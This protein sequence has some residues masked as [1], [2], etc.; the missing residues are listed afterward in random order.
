MRILV[1]W[2]V[3]DLV[4]MLLSAGAA[5]AV[6][7]GSG[8]QDSGVC[9]RRMP[10][11]AT[12][13]GC[14]DQYRTPERRPA[15]RGFRESWQCHMF[16]SAGAGIY[17]LTSDGAAHWKLHNPGAGVYVVQESRHQGYADV[18]IGGPGFCQPVLRW[19][20]STCV[21]DHNVTEQ[22]GGCNGR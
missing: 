13:R 7:Q 3:H 1:K 18:M 12:R 5:L 19:D 20:G 8:R 17:L 16:G 10:A 2:F 22:P 6:P 21:F 15:P 9:R 11:L 14:S 4:L